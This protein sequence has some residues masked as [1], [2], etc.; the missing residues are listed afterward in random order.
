M[1]FLVIYGYKMQLFFKLT[2]TFNNNNKKKKS[3][4]L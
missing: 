1:R 2:E 3:E 4:H